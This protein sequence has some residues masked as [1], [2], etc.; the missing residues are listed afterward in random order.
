M[1]YKGYEIFRVKVYSVRK[2]G[3]LVQGNQTAN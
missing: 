1:K 3:Q 2:L